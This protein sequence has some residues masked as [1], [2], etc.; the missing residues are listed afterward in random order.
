MQAESP[1]PQW[2]QRRKPPVLLAGNRQH[3]KAPECPVNGWA[4]DSVGKRLPA[5][6]PSGAR[7]ATET[8]EASS[9]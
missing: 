4:L 3:P 6:P 8:G 1:A 7:P 9:V 5:Q 2:G